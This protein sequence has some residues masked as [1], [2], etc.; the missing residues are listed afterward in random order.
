MTIAQNP[1]K[2]ADQYKE[3]LDAVKDSEEKFSIL[4]EMIYITLDD[5]QARLD[6][7]PLFD[8]HRE[9]LKEVEQRNFR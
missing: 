7:R 1:P 9:F 3:M 8:E 2:T 5:E 6:Y 4:V